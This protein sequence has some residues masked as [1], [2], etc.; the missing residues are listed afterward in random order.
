MQMPL[1]IP[2]VILALGALVLPLLGALPRMRGLCLVAAGIAGVA[3]VALWRLSF[4]LPAGWVAS[5]WRPLALFGAPLTFEADTGNWVLAAALV[6]TGFLALVASCASS[7]RP[8]AFSLALILGATG[9]GVAAL[10]ATSFAALVV[11]WG[12]TDI[13]LVAAMLQYGREGTQRAGLALLS[14]A[15]AT[16]VLWAAP[17]LAETEGISGFIDLAHFSGISATLLQIAVILRLG[18]VPLHLWRPI[19]LQTDPARLIP[20]IFIPTLLG[21]DLLTYLPALT[22][23]L[24]SVLF[25]LAAVTV[26]VGGVDAW[27]QTDERS[28]LAG[29]MV[30][31]TGLAVLAVANAGQQAVATAVAAAVAWALS[32]TIFALTPGWSGRYFWRAIPSL[33]ALLSLCGLPGTLGFVVR[34]TAYSGLEADLVVLSVAL[35]GEAF[36]VAALVRLWFWAEPRPFVERRLFEPV[37]LAIFAVAAILLLLTGLSPQIF[38]GR[39]QDTA[40]LELSALIGQGGV[41]GWAGWALP[42][43]AGVT[44]FLAGEGLRQR[45]EAGWRGLGTMLRLE[46]VYGLLYVGTRLIASLLRG[47]ASVVEG[48]GALL[49]TTVIL[50]IILLYLTGSQGP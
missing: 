27:S 45:M 38:S 12:L 36:A 41:T 23:G 33:L 34:F 44:L 31:E 3:L 16:S 18:L 8:A 46:W 39:G 40:L 17:L 9:A 26:L 42:L 50:L 28:S 49:W 5:G 29:V 1:L 14:G 15:L 11:A 20:L 48:E 30:A 10:F 13:L 25:A 19:D 6:G 37:L 21:F 47:M 4:L 35:L 7:D 24:P 22:A 32:V 43:V 2:I